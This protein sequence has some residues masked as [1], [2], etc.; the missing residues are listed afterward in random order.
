MS[1]QAKAVSETRKV[2]G[3]VLTLSTVPE[4]PKSG[5]NLLRLK[6]ADT[7]GKPVSNA[8]VVFIY[9]MPMPGMTDTKV[10]ATYKEG[11]YEGKAML[12]MSGAWDVT[13]NITISGKPPI[14]EKF[15]L[16]VGGGM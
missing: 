7:A 2:S 16:Q 14:S 12:G 5:E 6:I 1:G 9:T 3:Y 13:A 15:I 10:P 4:I 11:I 8:Q